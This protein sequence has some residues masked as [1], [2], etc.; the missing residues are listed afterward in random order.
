MKVINAHNINIQLIH[1]S[2]ECESMFLSS[3]VIFVI[4][5]KLCS[6]YFG[7]EPFN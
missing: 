6:L 2:M 7:E 5:C 1:H 4:M 3:L